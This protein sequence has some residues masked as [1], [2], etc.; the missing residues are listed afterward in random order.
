MVPFFTLQPEV[1]PHHP[2]STQPAFP[3]QQ[4]YGTASNVSAATFPD[5]AS[6]VQPPPHLPS[7]TNPGG[8]PASGALSDLLG[9]ESELTNIQ[10]SITVFKTY[11][12]SLIF[13]S[14]ASNVNF[15]KTFGESFL[16]LVNS[17]RFCQTLGIYSVE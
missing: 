11:Q 7:K 10:V 3:H 15:Q 8:G 5:G 6:M 9:L 2:G 16:S 13:V 12:K 4:A 17:L 1:L 14:K